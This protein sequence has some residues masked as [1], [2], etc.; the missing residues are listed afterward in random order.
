LC[1]RLCLCICV[2][3][4][5]TY[6][7]GLTEG[8]SYGEK[9]DSQTMA[10]MCKENPLWMGERLQ[11]MMDVLIRKIATNNAETLTTLVG[12]FAVGD[13]DVALKVKTV[14][15]KKLNGDFDLNAY[16]EITFSA[17][18]SGYCSIPFVFGFGETYKYFKKVNAGCCA[19]DGIDIGSYVGQN[20][21]VFVADKKIQT[22]FAN[23]F[24]SM[25]TGATQWLTWLEFEGANMIDT[26]NYK[27][28]TI[29]EPRT[30]IR[31][32]MTYKVDC[33]ITYI[34]L[35]LANKLVG[36]P[37]NLYSVGDNFEGVN[38]VNQFTIVNP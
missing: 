36:L 25:A 38:F 6:D 14:A 37:A 22:A 32:D 24:V 3:L 12:D 21:L 27:Q 15:T 28:T 29:V 11:A 23:D 10:V 35:K 7:L 17:S 13:N 20:D 34:N 2:Q 4:S 5:T 16:E 33:G 9:F 19:G 31:F 8:V 26:D 1:C 18:N 30:G